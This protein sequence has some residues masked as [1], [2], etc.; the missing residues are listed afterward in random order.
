MNLG[1]VS[2]GLQTEAYFQLA[3]PPPGC[4]VENSMLR[5]PE[6]GFIPVSGSMGGTA[7]G[8]APGR[9][10]GRSQGHRVVPGPLHPDQ[11]FP[12]PSRDRLVQW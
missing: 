10:P 2:V 7:A 3:H 12:R 1:G 11:H 6:G 8:P 4:L 5:L 9:G